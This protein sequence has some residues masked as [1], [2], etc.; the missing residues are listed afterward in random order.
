MKKIIK[1]EKRFEENLRK[2]FNDNNARRER[3][4]YSIKTSCELCESYISGFCE[5]CPFDFLR[6]SAVF[7]GC[8]AFI[9]MITRTNNLPIDI[10]VSGI[11]WNTSK[12]KEARA[13]LK[14]LYKEAKKIIKF[15]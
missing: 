7:F 8:V 2:R 5:E 10:N 1:I 13:F 12:D 15:V 14:L 3:D 9:I 11:V 4:M 6:S